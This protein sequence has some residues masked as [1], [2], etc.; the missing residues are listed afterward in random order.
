MRRRPTSATR[1]RR[2]AARSVPSAGAASAK[3]EDLKVRKDP[4]AKAQLELVRKVEKLFLQGL[5]EVG[6]TIDAMGKIHLAHREEDKEKS[7][8]KG[9]VK[10]KTMQQIIF[11]L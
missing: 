11:S 7:P 4:A 6:G 2:P 9:G 3:R 5:S 8:A 10:P 1:P